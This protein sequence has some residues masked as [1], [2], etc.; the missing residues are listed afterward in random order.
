MW[1]VALKFL[2]LLQIFTDVE[3]YH[4]TSKLFKYIT[5]PPLHLKGKARVVQVYRVL[6]ESVI[7]KLDINV[8]PGV[9]HSDQN[10]REIVDATLNDAMVGREGEFGLMLSQINGFIS[11]FNSLFHE[12]ILF[13]GNKNYMSSQLPSTVNSEKDDTMKSIYQGGLASFSNKFNSISL[14]LVMG[15]A[16]I[17]KS[18]LL[19]SV[20]SELK[21]TTK[22]QLLLTAS[23]HEHN[24]V[25]V[26]GPW[27]RL[28]N[29][30]FCFDPA[31]NAE[32]RG[33]IVIKHLSVSSMRHAY[34]LKDLFKIKFKVLLYIVSP[35][36]ER[37]I[38]KFSFFLSF[39]NIHLK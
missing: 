25:L 7:H 22:A 36:M 38:S 28:V 12:D 23:N 20:M 19:Y 9:E 3:T 21:L 27:V 11:K 5:L 31:L 39:Q 26:F 13:P 16:G 8:V 17:G 1:N 6:H 14:I 4:A 34:L 18:K 29:D 32:E 24:H 30:L 33:A 10:C 15:H 35:T 2:V 37:K